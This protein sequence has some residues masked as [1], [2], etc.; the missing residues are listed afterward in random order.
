[1]GGY[2]LDEGTTE[3][4]SGGGERKL[5]WISQVLFGV[6]FISNLISSSQQLHDISIIISTL[7]IRKLGISHLTNKGWKWD[8]KT[9]DVLL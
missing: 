9:P 4:G 6:D 7:Q 3:V 8:F 1:M 2:T 5:T